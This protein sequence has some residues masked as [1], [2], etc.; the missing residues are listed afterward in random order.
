M[1]IEQQ[2]IE[3][4]RSGQPPLNEELLAKMT[5][6]RELWLNGFKEHYLEKYIATG[7]S[8]VKVLVGSA[9]TGKTHLLSCIEL[10]AKNLGYQ[11]VY[12]SALDYSLND[13]PGLYRAIVKEIDKERIVQGL[14]CYVATV[15]GY[16][17]D[18]YDGT[19]PLA[20]M[21]YDKL[22]RDLAVHEIK[23][24][25]GEA[26]KD[27]DFGPSFKAFAYGAI[28]NRMINGNE[29][30]IDLAL[31]W[32]SGE[33]L[34]RREKQALHLFEGLQK[35]NARY[36]LNSLIN[37]LTI[38]GIKGLVVAIDDLEAMTERSDQ[39]KRFVY[40]TNAIKDV[41]ELFRQLID[42][43]E[44]LNNFLLLLAGRREMIEDEKRGF[45]SYEALWMRL[46]TGLVPSE[47]FNPLADIVDTDKHLQANGDN[48]PVRVNTRL[49]ELFREIDLKLEY[50][51]L[52]D[53]SK[54]SNLQARVIEA[55]S[56]APGGKVR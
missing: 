49:R 16:G 51:G 46:Q 22:G 43:G 32:L 29:T 6:G 30:D 2:D 35:T 41:C 34:E 15:L 12:L 54:Y 14:C 45:K 11:T 10:D 55:V 40:S 28:N 24:A 37:L 42:D 21:L 33:K 1:K 23:K 13:L 52:P 50:K 53:L 47:R 31:K 19:Q 18:R 7:G 20:P 44:L 27:V 17:E 4:L 5:L 25:A 48:F 39:T 26:F 56:M 9:G 8:K 3:D 38:A 36:W